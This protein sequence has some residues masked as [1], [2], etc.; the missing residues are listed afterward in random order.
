M[1]LSILQ[2]RFAVNVRDVLFIEETN[3]VD[4]SYDDSIVR[5]FDSAKVSARL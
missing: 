1:K 5:Y 2:F 3:L 4:D